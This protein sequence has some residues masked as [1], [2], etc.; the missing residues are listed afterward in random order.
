MSPYKLH[1]VTVST[2][3]H[4]NSLHIVS[5]GMELR[6]CE[7]QVLLLYILRGCRQRGGWC[8]GTLVL[9]LACPGPDFIRELNCLKVRACEVSELPHEP[10][11]L[12]GKCLK[13][14]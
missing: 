7:V 9:L 10:A 11:K 8:F 3:K 14:I 13:M 4:V 12:F 1:R 6:C 2:S 5:K